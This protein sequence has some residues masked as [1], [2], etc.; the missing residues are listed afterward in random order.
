VV[1]LPKKANASGKA[2]GYADV[3]TVTWMVEPTD[4]VQAMPVSDGWDSLPWFSLEQGLSRGQTR[5]YRASMRGDYPSIRKLQRLLLAGEAATLVAVR[6]VTQDNA[7]KKTAGVDGVKLVRRS[8][9]L[10]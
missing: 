1:G 5:I 8:T 10:G 7:G 9:A 4:G 3:G 6:R 2:R